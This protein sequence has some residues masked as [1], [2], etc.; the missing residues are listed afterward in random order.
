MRG[1]K[2]S[3]KGGLQSRVTRGSKGGAKEWFQGARKWAEDIDQEF[4]IEELQAIFAQKQHRDD[5]RL[6]HNSDLG[7]LADPRNHGMRSGAPQWQTKK[8]DITQQDIDQMMWQCGFHPPNQNQECRRS[9]NQNRLRKNNLYRNQGFQHETAIPPVRSW[10]WR[11]KRMGNRYPKPTI[12]FRNPWNGQHWQKSNR[13]LYGKSFQKGG[14]HK[15]ERSEDPLEKGKQEM[16]HNPVKDVNGT[17]N[18]G[19]SKTLE[20]CISLFLD[21]KMVRNAMS[22]LREVGFFIKW[23]GGW[24]ALDNLES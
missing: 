8:W 11:Q 4:L 16:D 21:D 10:H 12:F 22:K 20:K 1:M 13:W 6:W 9:E 15:D 7:G 2:G 17:T 18:K 5:G 23:G 19:K 14:F 3:A 24:P